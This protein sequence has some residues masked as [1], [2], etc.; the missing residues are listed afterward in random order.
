MGA[1]VPTRLTVVDG[2]PLANACKHYFTSVCVFLT[3]TCKLSGRT[4]P[5]RKRRKRSKRQNVLCDFGSVVCATAGA[6]YENCTVHMPLQTLN[7]F[8]AMALPPL[9][10]DFEQIHFTACAIQK[11]YERS[12]RKANSYKYFLNIMCIYILTLETQSK[13][14]LLQHLLNG[15]INSNIGGSL[16]FIFHRWLCRQKYVVG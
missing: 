9:S 4:I 1:H 15:N 14:L 6:F 7:Q 11:S 16:V 5:A 8:Y 13:I 12:N 10:E 2:L 3:I